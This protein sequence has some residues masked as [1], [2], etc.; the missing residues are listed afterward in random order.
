MPKLVVGGAPL[1]PG[2]CRVWREAMALLLQV[3]TAT[4]LDCHAI[5]KSVGEQLHDRT[6]PG[7]SRRGFKMRSCE[8]CQGGA[9]NFGLPAEGK[10]PRWCAACSKQHRGAANVTALRCEAATGES[11]IRCPLPDRHVLNHSYHCKCNYL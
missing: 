5:G 11:I 2:C 9:A 1:P 8:D 4:G 10:R 7:V 6:T 3:R